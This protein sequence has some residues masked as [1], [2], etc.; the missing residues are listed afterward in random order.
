MIFKIFKK[1]FTTVQYININFLFASLKLLT[2]FGNAYIN[3]PQNSLLCDWLMFSSVDNSCRENAQEL[4]CH[5]RLPVCTFSV[6]IDAL[7]PL[8][9]VTERIFKIN[10]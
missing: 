4:I 7:G 8:K 5:R 2:N 9:R 3:P 10:K 1:L 6:K